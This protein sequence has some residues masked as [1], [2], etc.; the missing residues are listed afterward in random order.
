M[1]LMTSEAT[2]FNIVT[3]SFNSRNKSRDCKARYQRDL[4]GL[5]DEEE[6]RA[7]AFQNAT[8]KGN[9]F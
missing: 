5:E 7:R 9:V 1:R 2:P 6:R 4:N 8:V 3:E